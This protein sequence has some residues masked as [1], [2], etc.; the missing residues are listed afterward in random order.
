MR[1]DITEEGLHK[2]L[3]NR[4]LHK[5]CGADVISK[6]MGELAPALIF[7]FSSS[8]RNGIIPADWRAV[9]VT[10]VF[11]KVE[12]YRFENC[13]PISLTSMVCKAMEHTVSCIMQYAENNK[14]IIQHVFRCGCSCEMQLL[15]LADELT[16]DLQLGKQIDLVIMPFSKAFDKVN[17]SLLLHK[18][19]H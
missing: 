17:H 8:L 11:K 2:L 7:I 18:L 1:L 4:N 3:W 14:I 15:S 16:Q 12:C 19:A 10:P 6:L 9:F 13:Y 5:A